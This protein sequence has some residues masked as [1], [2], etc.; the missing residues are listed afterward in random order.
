[1]ESELLEDLGFHVDTAMDG[2]MALEQLTGAAPDRY[3]LVLMDIQ[4]PVMNGYEA[5]QLIRSQEDPIL[6]R[7]PIVALSANAFDEDRRM[8]RRSGMNAHMAKPLN[9][10]QL[11]ELMVDII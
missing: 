8:S 3:A 6:R 7:I 4:M 5:A 11:L 9:T 10:D 1:M 2:R